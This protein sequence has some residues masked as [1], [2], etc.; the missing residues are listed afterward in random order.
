M[1]KS[2][3]QIIW[4]CAILACGLAMFSLAGCGKKGP[5]YLEDSQTI[6]KAPAPKADQTTK[7]K[8]PTK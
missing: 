6:E 2:I 7:N 8:Q 4:F 3:H 5:L 1:I